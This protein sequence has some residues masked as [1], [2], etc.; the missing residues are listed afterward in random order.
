MYQ[1]ILNEMKARID[2][3][4]KHYKELKSKRKEELD[5]LAKE[6]ELLMDRR[7]NRKARMNG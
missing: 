6:V 1:D 3:K 5:E 7:R 2:E 4:E